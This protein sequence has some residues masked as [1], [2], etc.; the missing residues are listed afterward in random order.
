[1]P[2]EDADEDANENADE[3]TENADEDTED[4]DDDAD[5]RKTKESRENDRGRDA[6]AE[7][8][9]PAA[10]MNELARPFQLNGE[11]VVADIGDEFSAKCLLTDRDLELPY[12]E[13]ALQRQMAGDK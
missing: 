9:P 1:M 12:T 3:D 2:V 7:S 11:E 10:R 4:A 13:E 6:V 8:N 5:G